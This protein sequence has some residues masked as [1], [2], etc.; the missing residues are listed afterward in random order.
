M[1]QLPLHIQ[2]R[3][4]SSPTWFQF[5]ARSVCTPNCAVLCSVL[6]WPERLMAPCPTPQSDAGR[7]LAPVLFLCEG[8]YAFC[9][10]VPFGQAFER[11]SG[12]QPACLPLAAPCWGLRRGDSRPLV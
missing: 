9:L 7:G 11:L 8:K 12:Q 6:C 4:R 2:V 10:E 3:S 1:L 5:P